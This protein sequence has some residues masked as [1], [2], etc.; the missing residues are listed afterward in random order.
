MNSE[1]HINNPTETNNKQNE[2]NKLKL[3]ENNNNVNNQNN[4]PSSQNQNNNPSQIE[5]NNLDQKQHTIQ[6]PQNQNNNPQSQNQNVNNN[7]PNSEKT[8]INNAEKNNQNTAIQKK[9]EPYKVDSSYL[10][11]LQEVLQKK[12]TLRPT[13]VFIPETTDR[14]KLNQETKKE[15][16]QTM[17][18]IIPSEATLKGIRTELTDGIAL[19]YYCKKLYIDQFYHIS[20]MF[21]CCPLYYNYHIS[22]EFTF[23][24]GVAYHLFDTKEYSN[25][26]SHDCCP[27]QTREIKIELDNFLVDTCNEKKSNFANLYKPFRCACSCLCACCSRPTMKVNLTQNKNEIGTIVEQRTLCSPT[28]YVYNLNNDLKY[29]IRGSCI[30]CGYCCKDM[31]CNCCKEAEFEIYSNRDTDYN[32]PEGKIK[33]VKRSGEKVRPDYEQIELDFP[34]TANCHDKILLMSATIFLNMLYF[35][36]IKNSNRCNGGPL[37]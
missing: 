14:T 12:G 1:T 3:N 16:N 10:E 4:N 33:K 2:E 23:Q 5:N 9:E 26:C 31:C 27:N 30:Q 20:D 11:R 37:D 24:Q 7:N 19:F 8:Q 13:T 35:Q 34:T 21:V 22:M 28:L 17:T 18:T 25:A 15:N 32:H 36:N 6:Q 29:K